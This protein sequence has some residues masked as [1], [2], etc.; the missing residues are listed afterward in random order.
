[1][2]GTRATAWNPTAPELLAAAS[3][4]RK[5]TVWQV[6]ERGP[7]ALVAVLAHHTDTVNSLAWMPDGRRL[8]CVCADGR[9]AMWDAL[10]GTFLADLSSYDTHCTMV[11]VSPEGLVATVGEDGLIVVGHPDDG[12]QN[13]A[14]RHYDCTVECC[15]WSHSGRTL[16]VGC[17]DGTVDLLSAGLCLV[18]T[19]DVPGAA[20]LTVEWAPDDASFVVGAAD[21]TLHFFAVGGGRPVVRRRTG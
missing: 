7:A 17:D 10:T 13:L 15:V 9:A 2:S 11:A 8:V 4:D 19:V 21:G 12:V 14:I 18:H 16:A 5:V 1:M 6:P 3:P 20:A